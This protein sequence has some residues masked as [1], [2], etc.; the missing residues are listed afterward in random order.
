MQTPLISV[1]V[2]VY[3]VE[4]YLRRCVDSILRQTYRNLEI[5]L[6][7]DGSTD[8]SGTICDACAQQDT[9]VKVIHQKNGGL[10]A[11]R[12]CGLETARGEYISFVDSD[13]LINDRMIETLYRD[14]AGQGADISA[15]GY[16]MFENQEELRPEEITAPV[17]CMTGKEA[18]RRILVSEEIGDFAWNKLYKK[19]LFQTIRYPEGRVFEDRHTGFWT[20]AIK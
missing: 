11:A 2:P 18:L 19:I 3:N 13:D 8:R 10:S 9:R 15:V 4:P 20:N 17:Q 6:V 1:I 16:R 12:N 7:D 5:L 14:L